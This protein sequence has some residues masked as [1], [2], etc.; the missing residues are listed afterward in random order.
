MNKLTDFQ[1]DLLLKKTAV[2]YNKYIKLFRLA[3]EEYKIR[4]GYYPSQMDDD[5]WI[6]SIGGGCG[7]ANIITSKDVDNSAK[8]RTPSNL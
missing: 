7:D 8:I 5:F 6:D 1:F 3:E 2:A 4:Y